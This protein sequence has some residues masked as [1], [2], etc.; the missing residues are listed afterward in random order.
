MKNKKQQNPATTTVIADSTS[1]EKTSRSAGFKRRLRYRAG[2]AAV[3]AI[4]TAIVVLLNILVG[5]LADRYPLSLDISANKAF[6]LSDQSVT[7]AKQVQQDIQLVIFIEESFFESPNTG[8]PELDTTLR[9][10]LTAL[11]QYNYHSNNK[12]TYKFLDPSQSPAEYAAYSK[13]EVQAGDMLFLCG[14]RYKT[15]TLY[16]ENS[17]NSS[18]LYTID[19]SNLQTTGT[20]SVNS[21]V[22]KMLA[23]A[24]HPLNIGNDHTVQVLTGHDEDR[25]VISGLKKIYELNGYNFEEMQINT[26]VDFNEKA[27][28]LL[29]P[30]PKNDYTDEELT[31]IRQWIDNDNNYDRQLMVYIHPT[32]NCPKLYT[33]LEQEYGI[34]VTDE[35]IVETDGNR[36]RNYFPYNA[37]A[38]VA[39]TEFTE[40]SSGIANIST[41]ETRRL[42]TTLPATIENGTLGDY[43]LP[44]TEYPNTAKLVK[45]SS[46]N[47]ETGASSEDILYNAPETEYPLTGAIVSC[48]NFHNNE[49]DQDVKRR[50]FVSGCT[51]MATTNYVQDSTLQNEEFLLD[52]INGITDIENDLIIS[53]KPLKNKTVAFNAKTQTILGLGVFTV[54]LPLALLI[55]CLVVYLRRK[56]L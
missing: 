18:D 12:V 31:R 20:Y 16:S 24:I 27:E 9:E 36:Y 55:V 43:A 11:K 21:N 15:S 52:V 3:I 49:T 1:M 54:G 13:Y 40:N 42:K 45:L 53:S 10:F 46:L 7:I 2:F 33:F 56:N 4:A 22:E 28:T 30:A 48:R 37:L 26:S 14:E 8:L 5:V 51:T 23:S 19:T 47:N 34:V 39:S 32:A 17:Q 35:I 50:V 29:I 38:D 25:D 44:L 41:Y 6:T